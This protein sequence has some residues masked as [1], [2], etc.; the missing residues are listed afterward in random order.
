MTHVTKTSQ[1]SDHHAH[2]APKPPSCAALEVCAASCAPSINLPPARLR[3]PCCCIAAVAAA[4][5]PCS[6]SRTRFQQQ[7]ICFVEY[8]CHRASATATLRHDGNIEQHGSARR[9]RA[10]QSS[11]HR[12]HPAPSHPAVY[13]DRVDT[14][15]LVQVLPQVPVALAACQIVPPFSAP[16]RRPLVIVI[17]GHSNFVSMNRAIELNTTLHMRQTVQ[18]T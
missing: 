10:F 13:F 3:I 16:R 12:P 9:A 7:E 14:V 1:K 15:A 18:P 4:I 17:G 11:A 8:P 2:T 6:P 5:M